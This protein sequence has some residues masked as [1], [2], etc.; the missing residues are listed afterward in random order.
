M[1]NIKDIV[2]SVLSALGLFDWGKDFCSNH[3]CSSHM[4]QKLKYLLDDQRLY[5]AKK[6]AQFHGIGMMATIFL[7]LDPLCSL[8]LRVPLII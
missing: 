1:G 7:H 3:V 2:S 6:P 4:S 8:V 5:N